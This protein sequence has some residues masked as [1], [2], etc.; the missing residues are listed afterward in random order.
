M[1][2]SSDPWAGVGSLVSRPRASIY[3]GDA[4]RSGLRAQPTIGIMI[5]TRPLDLLSNAAMERSD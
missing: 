4:F 2:L 5:S 1:T 3:A